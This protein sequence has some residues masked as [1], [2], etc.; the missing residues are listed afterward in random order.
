MKYI[1][2]TKNICKNFKHQVSV[3]KVSM[4]IPENSIYGLLGA[5]GAGKSTILKMIAGIY[6]PTSGEICFQGEKW[7]RRDLSNIG[8]LIENTSYYY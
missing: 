4:T 1:L 5:N 2:E 7:D 3:D 6:K 8:A